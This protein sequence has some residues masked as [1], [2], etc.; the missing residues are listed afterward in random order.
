M[1]WRSLASRRA[2]LLS[3]ITVATFEQGNQ[4]FTAAAT[5][6]GVSRNG[7]GMNLSDKVVLVSVKV[8]IHAAFFN[9]FVFEFSWLIQFSVYFLI[10]QW[11]RTVWN[12]KRTETRSRIA[13]KRAQEKLVNWVSK[14]EKS[15]ITNTK[16]V[17]SNH[18]QLG[19]GRRQPAEVFARFIG[20]SK[21]SE[22]VGSRHQYEST[23][24]RLVQEG[25]GGEG[26]LAMLV[27]RLEQRHRWRLLLGVQIAWKLVEVK[28]PK[29]Q[30]EVDKPNQPFPSGIL[31]L[32]GEW[33][34][35]VNAQ[36]RNLN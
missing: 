13:I 8:A 21:G 15:D 25:R 30:E 22:T 3:R 16:N 35:A 34:T 14:L 36:N 7:N 6:V 17:F 20:P 5:S 4:T 23:V 29:V 10:F 12:E 11:T 19:R 28:A 2:I 32:G 31:N 18:S 9:R 1:S 24:R 27:L 26:Q 33:S